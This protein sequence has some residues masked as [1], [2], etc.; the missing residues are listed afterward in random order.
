MVAQGA[1]PNLLAQVNLTVYYNRPTSGNCAANAGYTVG[2]SVEICQA[3]YL[4]YKS[5]SKPN[6]YLIH[7]L[8]HVRQYLDD[9]VGY[10]ITNAGEN[11]LLSIMSGGDTRIVHDYN[12]YEIEAMTCDN[13]VHQSAT[14]GNGLLPLNSAPCNLTSG[15]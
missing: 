3:D 12:S 2:T 13:S 8:I 5:N 14:S 6:G 9:P 4:T 7:E 1:D 10:T 15:K 11:F